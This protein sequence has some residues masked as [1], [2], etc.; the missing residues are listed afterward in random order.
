LKPVRAF[1]SIRSATREASLPTFAPS[2]TCRPAAFSCRLTRTLIL[3]SALLAPVAAGAQDPPAAILLGRVTDAATGVALEGVAVTVEGTRAGTVTDSAG[4]FRLARVP[5]GPQVLRAERLGY[6]TARVT[7][8]VPARGV[9]PRD[10]A[11][12]PQALQ[13]DELIVTADPAGRARGE[14]GTA[15]VIGEE[16][17][18]AQVAASLAGVLE[19]VPGTPLRPPGLDGVQQI[20]LRAVPTAFAG[21]ATGVLPGDIASFGTLIVLDGVPLSNNANLQ[22]TG[23]RGEVRP[24]T[25]A[26]GGIDLRRLPAT[27]IERVEVIRGVP[28]ARYGDLTH[29]AIV[30]ETRAGVVEPLVI[31]RADPRGR[32]ASVVA[33]AALGGE[34]QTATLTTDYAHT[35]LMPGVNDDDAQRVTAQLAHRLRRGGAPGVEGER[36]GWVLDTRVDFAAVHHDNPEQPD[37]QPGS[38]SHGLDRSLRVVQR[39]RFGLTEASVLEGTAAVQRSWQRSRTQHLL[40]RGALPFTRRIEEGRET[41]H[42]V[43]GTYPG[44]VTLEGDP[45]LLYGRGEIDRPWSRAGLEGRLRAGGELRREWNAGPGYIFDIEFPP[46]SRFN[47]VQGFDRPRRFDQIPALATTALYIDQRVLRAFGP[48]HIDVQAGARL[49]VLHGGEW[50]LSGVRDA[51]AQP[52]LNAQLALG[53]ALRLRAGWGQTGKL[54]TLGQL[55]PAPQYYD[56]INVN[57]FANIPAERLAILTTFIRDPTNPDLGYARGSKAEAG[58][59]LDLGRSGGVLALVAFDDQVR[60]AVGVRYEPDFILRERFELADSTEGTGRPPDII[61]PASAIDSVP[62]LINRPANSLRL[63]SRGLELTAALP[64]WR[65]LRTRLEVQGAWIRT[66]F[67]NSELEFG[68]ANRFGDFQL[69]ARQARSPYWHGASAFGE[70]VVV[71]YRVVHHQPHAGLVLLASVQHMARERRYD[72]AATDT[73]AFE[74]YITRSGELVAVPPER[75]A[76]PEFS[77]LRVPRLGFL[78]RPTEVAADW[79]MSVQVSK[80]LPLGGRLSFYGFNLLDRPGRIGTGALSGRPLPAARFGVEAS[81]PPR[82]LV[83]LARSWR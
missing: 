46:Q 24:T 26:G 55:Y 79:L 65:R 47:G 80:T 14:L 10:I 21:G 53:N 37:V 56:V 6:A 13:M 19:L 62:L 77:D 49:D 72:I 33:G 50:W 78:V 61:E 67:A 8:T 60:G 45:W 9:V 44:L 76:D 81:F 75:R 28:S 51:V 74:G 4:V 57:W 1:S 31:A 17:I 73:L 69:D 18:R 82:A 11:L 29:G 43:G 70:R 20:G 68:A 58:V 42:Y 12:A 54:P 16:A 66:R 39:A 59:E 63:G 38:F 83:E 25:S 3:A 41:G 71:T 7:I 52:R 64:E 32:E 30:V 23:A 2:I 48:A 36:R 27:T 40:S 15:T 35:R 5:A 22:T 34:A